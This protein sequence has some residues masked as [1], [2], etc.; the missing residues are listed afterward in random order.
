MCASPPSKTPNATAPKQCVA[1][2]MAWRAR[3]HSR[4]SSK[5]LIK[6]RCARRGSGVAS[7]AGLELRRIHMLQHARLRARIRG[8]TP[9]RSKAGSAIG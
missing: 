1:A 5:H 2:R 6:H 7:A 8:T 9:E 4:Q 3:S